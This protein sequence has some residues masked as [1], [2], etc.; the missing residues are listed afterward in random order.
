MAVVNEE[1]VDVN[2]AGCMET[3]QEFKRWAR[4]AVS[5]LSYVPPEGRDERMRALLRAAFWRGS[6]FHADHASHQKKTTE[7]VNHPKHYNE[8]PSGV[9]C[10]D[11]VEWLDFNT[12][13]ALK[14]L[15]RAGLKPGE[16]TLRDLKK[17]EWYF[18][19]AIVHDTL[20][21]SPGRMTEVTSLAQRVYASA[22]TSLLGV[23]VSALFCGC[24]DRASRIAKCL[25][26]IDK[27]IETYEK[28]SA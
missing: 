25:T 22:P 10:V 26:A 3:M 5:D 17:S 21:I 27:E 14:Y 7:A 1:A 4:Q 24:E 28:R 9:E 20:L 23:V 6:N 2:C 8:H 15:W 18:A 11:L 12:G 19:R 16:E 13:S